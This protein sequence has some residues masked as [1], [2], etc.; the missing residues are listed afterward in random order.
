M[1][2]IQTSYGYASCQ[3]SYTSETTGT[4]KTEH[5]PKKPEWNPNHV[6]RYLEDMSQGFQSYRKEAVAYYRE[7]IARQEGDGTLTMEELKKQIQEYFPEYT[8]TKSEP[9]EVK[10][11][12]FY[13]YIDEK[14]LQRLMSDP[15]Y[16]AKVFGLM[17]SELQGKKGYTLQYSDGRNVTS[18]LTG[19]IFSLAEKNKKY[20]GADGIPYLGSCTSD[21][22]FS[23]SDSHPQVRSMSYLYDNIDPAKSAAKDRQGNVSDITAKRIAKA[24]KKR[25]EEK[26]R[27]E[28]LEEKKEQQERIEKR[29]DE[30]ERMETQLLE[31][32]QERADQMTSGSKY[33]S[34]EDI[35]NISGIGNTGY[36]SLSDFT[37]YLADTYR[38]YGNGI[39]TVSKTFLRECMADDEKRFQL[40]QMLAEADAMEKDAKENVKGYQGMKIHIDAEGNMETET[41]GGSVSFPEGKRAAQIDASMSESDIQAVMGLLTKDLA[42][43]ESGVDQGLC[44]ETEVQKVKAMIQKAEEKIRQLS[45]ND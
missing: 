35:R 2:T 23:S 32:W 43:C 17:D 34:A 36:Q 28:R 45:G 10:N 1:N 25:L 13:L 30:K 15:D 12:V 40:E 42:E 16:R 38:T 9:S 6:Y 4:E 11:G 39:T 44:D 22:P 3:V 18:H 26:K 24:K 21:H 20:A 5:L 37:S 7:M 14:N 19:S 33:R 29:R 27:K 41:Y 31:E 8:L